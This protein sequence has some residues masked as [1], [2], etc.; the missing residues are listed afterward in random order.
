MKKSN[1][2][3]LG[4]ACVIMLLA[5]NVYSSGGNKA[6]WAYE[7]NEGPESWGN[8][9]PDYEKCGSGMGQSPVNISKTV[10]A[11]VSDIEFNYHTS[12]LKMINN[13][14]TIQVNYSPGS[15]ITVNGRTYNLRSSN[16]LPI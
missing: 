11:N 13:G 8:L 4:I 5:L 6:H 10:G 7:G 1:L 16:L 14:H 3:M 9:S 15:S 2:I 12:P